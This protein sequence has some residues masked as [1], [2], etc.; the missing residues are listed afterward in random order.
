MNEALLG[1]GTRSESPFLVKRISL[2]ARDSRDLREKRDGSDGSSLRVAPVAYVLLVSLTIHER[3]FTHK[4]NY[5][6]SV[7][8]CTEPNAFAPCRINGAQRPVLATPSRSLRRRI[9]SRCA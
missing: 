7:T 5:L 4:S 8:E 1:S 9:V 3:R 2:F 6:L